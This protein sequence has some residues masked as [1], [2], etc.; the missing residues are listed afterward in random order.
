M[1]VRTIIALSAIKAALITF[2][3][4]WIGVFTAEYFTNELNDNNASSVKLLSGIGLSALAHVILF[5]KGIK[6]IGSLVGFGLCYVTIP[7]Y[8]IHCNWN[9]LNVPDYLVVVLI[10]MGIFDIKQ[11]IIYSE[12]KHL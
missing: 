12:E 9:S 3:F 7:A 2:S 4:G 11:R 8:T 10:V 5:R 6:K 1:S